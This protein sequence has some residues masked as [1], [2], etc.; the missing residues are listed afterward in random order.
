VFL[1]VGAIIGQQRGRHLEI[2]NSFELVFTVEDGLIVIDRDYYRTKEEQFKQVF[3]E[4]DFIGWYTTGDV[5]SPADIMVHRQICEISESP[6]LLKLNP[7]AK[8]FDQLPVSVFESIIETVDGDATM[9]FV[10]LPYVLATEEAERIGVDHV[11]RMASSEASE[12]S[13]VA[14]HLTAQHSAI[15]MLHSRVRLVLDY[16]KAMEK[17]EVPMCHETLR[18]AKSLANRLPVLH[19]DR[20]KKDFN[21]VIDWILFSG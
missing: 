4:M 16:V 7:V 9:L 2:M 21:E 20:L 12:S 1:V 18:L 19:P 11:A 14:D 15:K 6:V 17:G 10:Q 5:P 8:N 3:S 13:L